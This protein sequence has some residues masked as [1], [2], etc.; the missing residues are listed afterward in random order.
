MDDKT[1]LRLEP[2]CAFYAVVLP[3]PGEIF[4]CF[5]LL[6]L[7]QMPGRLEIC[8]DLV[9]IPGK[10]VSFSPNLVERL[11]TVTEE[12]SLTFCIAEFS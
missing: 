3:Q 8:L 10:G 9:D 5:G 11:E 1:R 4:G 2:F 7:L 12:L 6:V